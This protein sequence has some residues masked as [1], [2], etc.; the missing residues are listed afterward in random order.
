[1]VN[2]LLKAWTVCY[3]VQQIYSPL[4]NLLPIFSESISGVSGN[5]VLKWTCQHVVHEQRLSVY[6]SVADSSSL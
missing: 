3:Q 2:L 6:R 5:V 4:V 1:M